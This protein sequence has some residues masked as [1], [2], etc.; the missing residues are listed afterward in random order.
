MSFLSFIAS[1]ALLG[2]ASLKDFK[3]TAAMMGP[4]ILELWGRPWAILGEWLEL[5]FIYL[6]FTA[7]AR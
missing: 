1:V 4:E 2:E 6:F 7:V 5:L 3:G